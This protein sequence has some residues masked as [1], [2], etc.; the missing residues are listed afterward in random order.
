MY[1]MYSDAEKIPES[2]IGYNLLQALSFIAR[3]QNPA[4]FSLSV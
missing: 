1:N 2:P 3:R 4:I